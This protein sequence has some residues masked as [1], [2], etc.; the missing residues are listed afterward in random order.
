MGHTLPAVTDL[1]K[2][3]QDALARFRRALRAEDQAALDSLFRSARY[4]VAALAYASNLLPFEMMLLGMLIEEREKAPFAWH[5]PGEEAH[6]GACL[7]H[8]HLLRLSLKGCLPRSFRLHRPH[9]A[10]ETIAASSL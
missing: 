3:E 4:H 8:V 2:N 1:L 7:G 5:Q 10:R 6:L 9:Y